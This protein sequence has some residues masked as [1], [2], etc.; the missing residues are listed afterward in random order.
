[1]SAINSGGV[2]KITCMTTGEFYIG[3]AA[4]SFKTRRN[5]HFKQLRRGEHH[6]FK[7]QR[8]WDKHGEASFMFEPVVVCRPEDAVMYEQ[9]IIDGMKPELNVASTAGSLLGYRHSEE[10]KKKIAAYPRTA[11]MRLKQSA[12]RSIGRNPKPRKFEVNSGKPNG[13]QKLSEGDV[14]AIRYIY[15]NK[16]ATMR[17]IA[18]HYGMDHHTISDICHRYTWKTVQ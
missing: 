12:R 9:L 8:A 10:A 18:G 3:S 15:D 5:N 16:L 1:M 11:E 2:Y 4:K 6:S 17:M 14:R 7:M 13:R